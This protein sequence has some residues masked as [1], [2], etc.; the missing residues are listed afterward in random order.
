M[1]N[2]ELAGKS[3]DFAKG[4]V[5]LTAKNFS[6]WNRQSRNINKDEKASTF[7]ES[8]YKLNVA[9]SPCSKMD[10]TCHAPMTAPYIYINRDA[11]QHIP[12]R[13]SISQLIYQKES[14]QT[15]ENVK[16]FKNFTNMKQTSINAYR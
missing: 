15:P 13:E 6:Q 2:S 7:E 1:R 9:I 3:G 12:R 16:D 11:K 14:R 5:N 8:M 10:P 4:I